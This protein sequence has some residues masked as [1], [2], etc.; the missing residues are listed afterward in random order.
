DLAAVHALD[1]AL[2]E[3]LD[4]A[5]GDAL[6]GGG[7]GRPFVAGLA[8]AAVRPELE[9]EPWGGAGELQRAVDPCADGAHRVADALDV[10]VAQPEAAPPAL[11]PRP[12][13]V[14][15]PRAPAPAEAPEGDAHAEDAHHA[16][17]RGRAPGRG[18]HDPPGPV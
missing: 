9:P 7:R 17:D 6:D 5:T 14:E 10:G 11:L 15:V 13:L 16:N 4:D 1:D 12:V 18:Q 8:V 3:G 2:R